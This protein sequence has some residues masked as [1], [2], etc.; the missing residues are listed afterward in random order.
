MNGKSRQFQKCNIKIICH[1]P[2]Y[3]FKEWPKVQVISFRSTPTKHLFVK[4]VAYNRTQIQSYPTEAGCVKTTVTC[5]K[6]HTIHAH[7]CRDKKWSH[8]QFKNRSS[9]TL[10][11]EYPRPTQTKCQPQDS[12]SLPYL[13][14]TQ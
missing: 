8:N 12:K 7:K 11:S 6:P 5:H 14:F 1:R 9:Q 10:T 2:K 4:A 3:P 13:N